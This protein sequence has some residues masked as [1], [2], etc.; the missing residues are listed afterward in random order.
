MNERMVSA[1]NGDYVVELSCP[2]CTEEFGV[3]VFVTAKLLTQGI[4]TR[5]QAGKYLRF[6]HTHKK[7]EGQNAS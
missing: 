2:V 3:A 6:H 7:C 5:E 1:E 4:P